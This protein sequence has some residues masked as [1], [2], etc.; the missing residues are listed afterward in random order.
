[1]FRMRNRRV[2][3]MNRS[4]G[5]SETPVVRRVSEDELFRQMGYKPETVN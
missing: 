3:R 1:M 2:R 4:A 5:E